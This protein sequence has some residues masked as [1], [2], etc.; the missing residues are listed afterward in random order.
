MQ[1]TGKPELNFLKRI[2]ELGRLQELEMQDRTFK[3]E[4][5]PE[6]LEKADSFAQGKPELFERICQVL[7]NVDFQTDQKTYLMAWQK[8]LSKLD[9]NTRTFNGTLIEP[10]EWIVTKDPAFDFFKENFMPSGRYLEW[11][12]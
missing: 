12:S 11:G 6:Y 7:N 10:C 1:P 8:S 9:T 4:R 2:V 5:M 3:T